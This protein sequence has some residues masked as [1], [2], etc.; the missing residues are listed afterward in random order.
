MS[1]PLT[2]DKTV[3][4]S[5][6]ETILLDI[7]AELSDELVPD[8]KPEVRI[9]DINEDSAKLALLL[10]INNPAKGSF[11]ASEVRRKIKTFLDQVDEDKHK[12]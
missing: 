8:S 2:L 5:T 3:N 7:G 9:T 12:D 11:I 1:I 4:L 6:V 10:K